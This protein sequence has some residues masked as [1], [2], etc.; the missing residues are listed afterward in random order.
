[1]GRSPASTDQG[2]TNRSGGR[3]MILTGPGANPDSLYIAKLVGARAFRCRDA[4]PG[5]RSGRSAPESGRKAPEPSDRSILLSRGRSR[6]SPL[7]GRDRQTAV[8]ITTSRFPSPSSFP[9][10]N[11]CPRFGD[12]RR[13]M[14]GQDRLTAPYDSQGVREALWSPRTGAAERS[15]G[16]QPLDC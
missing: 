12:A 11:G 1:S 10:P 15:Q 4:R 7:V 5:Q 3:A 6:G 16:R 8:I 14:A 9:V 2:S 13:T